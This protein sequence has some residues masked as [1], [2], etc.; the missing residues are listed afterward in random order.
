MHKVVCAHTCM[1]MLHVCITRA[2]M[3]RLHVSTFR[4]IR[5]CVHMYACVCDMCIHRVFFGILHSEC[6]PFKVFLVTPSVLS[7]PAQVKRYITLFAVQCSQGSPFL[8]LCADW[9][10]IEAGLGLGAISTSTQ[11][12]FTAGRLRLYQS[13][14]GSYRAQSSQR[15]CSAIFVVNC[16][17][18]TWLVSPI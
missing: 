11:T 14:T 18:V 15:R 10:F 5:A 17:D 6:S 3:Y 12:G 8:S 4:C 1:C 2:C 16:V 7:E 13:H 9:E